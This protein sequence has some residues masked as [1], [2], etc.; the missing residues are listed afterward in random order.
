MRF[1]GREM[2]HKDIG[3]NLMQKI[4]DDLSQITKVEF[5]PKIDGRQIMM[6][7]SPETKK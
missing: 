6:V 4:I 5:S 3:M 7:L 2:A 1:R